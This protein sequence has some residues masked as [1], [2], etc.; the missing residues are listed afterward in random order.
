MKGGYLYIV[1]NPIHKGFVKV[2]V[3][4]DIKERL[5]VY[6]T[7]DPHRKYKMEFY[8]FHPDCYTAEKKIKQMMKHFSTDTIQRGEWFKISIP[9]AI[10]RLEE[11][12]E[13][14]NNDPEKY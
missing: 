11:Q 13:D 5:R 2:G 10:S 14:F 8:I 3:T 7:A 1:T 6:Q 4:E 12:V 9:I